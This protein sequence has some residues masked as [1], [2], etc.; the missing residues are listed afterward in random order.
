[1]PGAVKRASFAGM[2]NTFLKLVKDAAARHNTVMITPDITGWFFVIS[3]HSEELKKQQLGQLQQ[4]VWFSREAQLQGAMK[5]GGLGTNPPGVVLKGAAAALAALEASKQQQQQQ[6][7][8]QSTPAAG[9]AGQGEPGSATG[10]HDSAQTQTASGS[11]GAAALRSAGSSDSIQGGAGSNSGSSRTGSSSLSSVAAAVGSQHVLKGRPFPGLKM[12]IGS[13]SSSS[14][15]TSSSQQRQEAAS[16]SSTA[17]AAAA[18]GASAAGGGSGPAGVQLHVAQLSMLDDLLAGAQYSQAAYG[19]VAAA[20]HLSNLGNAIKMLATLPHF[21]AI[22]GVWGV[23]VGMDVTGTVCCAASLSGYGCTGLAGAVSLSGG[24]GICMSHRPDNWAWACLCAVLCC[25]VLCCGVLWCA[26]P[27]VP[28]L[29]P[30]SGQCTHWQASARRTCCWRPGTMTHS[31]AAAQHSTAQHSIEAVRHV[32]GPC[33]R[34]FQHTDSL[35]SLAHV[36][37]CL[38]L[39][40]AKGAPCLSATVMHLCCCCLLLAADC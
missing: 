31:G 29:R 10:S 16:G 24:G 3:T 34:H 4:L 39:Q 23:C 9:A 35:S 21:N 30:T 33:S 7:Q 40:R 8:Q 5:Q 13:S 28:P 11:S 14:S 6:Q 19:Y 22:T 38:H 17:T 37:A 26:V 15:R 12:H 18:S 25:A 2:V 36:P 20:G 27:Q 32:Q 1:M